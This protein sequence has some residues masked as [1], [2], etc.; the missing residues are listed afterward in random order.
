[1]L[2]KRPSQC[3]IDMMNGQWEKMQEERMVSFEP[4]YK[5]II[6]IAPSHESELHFYT[7]WVESL[8][9]NYIVLKD[10]DDI[11]ENVNLLLL[12]GGADFGTREIRDANEERWFK[13]AY[14]RIPIVGVCRGM[15]M[16]NVVMGG[17][18]KNIDDAILQH[19]S[20][21][22]EVSKDKFVKE[23][24]FHSIKF[25]STQTEIKVNSRHHMAIDKVAEDFE[26]AAISED[27]IIEMVY[28]KNSI[29]VQWHPEREEVRGE[30][31]ETIVSDW[32]KGKLNINF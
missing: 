13:Q 31:A 1:M 8:G 2:N 22:I 26:V 20:S 32:I 16:A 21:S 18:L 11:D 4:I 28:G 24:C 14:G 10:D 17:S 25:R 5:K 6:A 12:C 3:L 15:E 27:D 19:A 29:F 23:S 7:N 9:F 30:K